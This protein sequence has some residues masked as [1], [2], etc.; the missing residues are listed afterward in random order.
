MDTLRGCLTPKLVVD[1][2]GIDFVCSVGVEVIYSSQG[3]EDEE[4]GL[5]GRSLVLGG[6][7]GI[8]D[9]SF[10]VSGLGDRWEG[11][12]TALLLPFELLWYYLRKTT[13]QFG[14]A[15]ERHVSNQRRYLASRSKQAIAVKVY[16]QVSKQIGR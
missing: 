16:R 2:V 14:K 6:M 11:A 8:L 1:G 3:S 10:H 9:V 7:E 12:E 13:C 15:R 5:G 4:G